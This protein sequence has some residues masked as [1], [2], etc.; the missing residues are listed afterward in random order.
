MET[1]AVL[2]G[3]GTPVELNAW[4]GEMVSVP[5]EKTEKGVQGQP[6]LSTGTLPSLRC[7]GGA[8]A[9]G[10]RFDAVISIGEMDTTIISW[11]PDPEAAVPTQSKKMALAL[12]MQPLGPWDALN[13]SPERLKELGVDSMA[14]V[15]RT[16]RVQSVLYP[17]GM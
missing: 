9:A 11:G 17:A 3:T 15:V 12:G 6:K 5:Y 14:H 1:E 16:G 2:S 8:T 13:V 10:R 7:C 4:T